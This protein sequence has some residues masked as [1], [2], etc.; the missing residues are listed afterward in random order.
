MVSKKRLQLTRPEKIRRY[1]MSKKECRQVPGRQNWYQNPNHKT[2]LIGAK[3]CDGWEASLRAKHPAMPSPLFARPPPQ[4]RSN[5]VLFAP[6]SFPAAKACCRLLH[7]AGSLHIRQRASAGQ[8][9]PLTASDASQIGAQAHCRL[10]YSQAPGTSVKEPASPVARPPLLKRSSIL[11]VLAKKNP[12]RLLKTHKKDVKFVFCGQQAPLVLTHKKE[13][14]AAIQII[15]WHHL[16]S[17]PAR[18]N[19]ARVRRRLYSSLLSG[20]PRVEMIPKNYC[21]R[22]IR[23]RTADN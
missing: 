11:F 7:F 14:R 19:V 10:C 23:R 5:I 12:R 16:Q 15:F 6:Q 22:P 9:F 4:K 1:L 20:S 17:T 18:R 8:L 13:N 2:I 21:S 3:V